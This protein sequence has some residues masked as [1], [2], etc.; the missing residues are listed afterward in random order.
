MNGAKEKIAAFLKY[1]GLDQEIR[2][3][4]LL[5]ET[6]PPELK[7]AREEFAAE[8]TVL[9]AL[10][11]KIAGWQADTARLEGEQRDGERTLESLKH[12]LN[13]IQNMKEYQ[14]A[15]KE[16]DTANRRT[17]EREDA[18]LAI[19][20]QLGENEPSVATLKAKLVELEGT[21]SEKTAIWEK[22][23]V[24]VKTAIETKTAERDALFPHIDASLIKRYRQIA[25]LRDPPLAAVA[26]G[27]C[28]ACHI[29]LPPQQFIELQRSDSLLICPSCQRLIYIEGR[30]DKD[31]SAA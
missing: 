12:R 7:Q 10:E 15:L 24:D 21:V 28:E 2:Q 29:Q 25:A 30:A 26:N 1:S 8:H 5:L 4:A 16:I 11:K 17:K 6:P 18:L 14:A 31:P 20:S 19:A 23:R 3:L 9:A 22:E 13:S 27:V